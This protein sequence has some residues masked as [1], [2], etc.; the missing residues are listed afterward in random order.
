M[1]FLPFQRGSFDGE[2]HFLYSFRVMTNQYR[3]FD[4]EIGG[5]WHSLRLN[6][7][8]LA[9]LEKELGRPVN[10][11]GKFGLRE[12]RAFIWAALLHENPKLKIETVGDWLEE[13]RQAD[14]MPEI[15]H[16]ISETFR[17]ANP[18]PDGEESP[19]E[20]VATGT[21]ANSKT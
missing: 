15:Y 14:K 11:F 10:E 12:T 8:A 6:F 16:A 3:Q 20:Q 1:A 9:A 4:M 5:E 7:N 13:F 21:G 19:N 17:L 2:P 18:K